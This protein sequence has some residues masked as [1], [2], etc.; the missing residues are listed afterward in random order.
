VGIDPDEHSAITRP[1]VRRR[2][3]V[4]SRRALLLRAG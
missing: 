2:Y 4:N 3:R 1:V